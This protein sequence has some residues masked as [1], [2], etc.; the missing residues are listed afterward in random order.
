[1]VFFSRY[2]KYF[3]IPIVTLFISRYVIPEEDYFY[4]QCCFLFCNCLVSYFTE[5][6]YL[7]QFQMSCFEFLH[8][9]EVSPKQIFLSSLFSYFFDVKLLSLLFSNLDLCY[10]LTEEHLQLQIS[11]CLLH[12]NLVQSNFVAL[13]I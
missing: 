7:R 13:N 2:F 11:I 10:T 4:F 8:F 3:N 1:M 6:N 9:Y 12:S 5:R